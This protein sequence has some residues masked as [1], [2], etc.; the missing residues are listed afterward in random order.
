MFGSDLTPD[1]V[2]CIL[3]FGKWHSSVFACTKAW[4][5]NP[6]VRWVVFGDTPFPGELPYNVKYSLLTRQE[7]IMRVGE[8]I[9]LDVRRA[10]EFTTQEIVEFIK[11]FFAVL[12][13]REFS[14][15]PTVG[16]GAI[17]VIYGNLDKAKPSAEDRS[18]FLVDVVDS[19][20]LVLLPNRPTTRDAFT[21]VPN[22]RELV[23]GHTCGATLW[24]LTVDWLSLKFGLKVTNQSNAKCQLRF[25]DERN[26]ADSLSSGVW[27]WWNG[28][29][30]S[31]ENPSWEYVYAPTFIRSAADEGS[32][33][34]GC[35]KSVCTTIDHDRGFMIDPTGL[36]E[37]TV[38]ESAAFERLRRTPGFRQTLQPGCLIDQV[39]CNIPFVWHG[40][41][42]Q[43]H[44]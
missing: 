6:S 13:E 18:S 5:H 44:W 34:L 35:R 37:L 17:D 20:N 25:P 12:F 26:S 30:C 31:V 33:S 27:Y 43:R 4:A 29:V 38:T 21:H 15:F 32:D 11:P 19:E 3:H 22:W 7:L 1:T 24:S 28:I 9:D 10:L 8:A 14:G 23:F 36:R 2:V 42:S 39:P 41:A 40:Y 16:L